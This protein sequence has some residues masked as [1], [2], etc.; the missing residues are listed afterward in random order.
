LTLNEPIYAKTVVVVYANKTANYEMNTLVAT[1]YGG[2]IYS[3]FSGAQIGAP[4]LGEHGVTMY[5]QT[6]FS[7][8][9][10]GFDI[11][12]HVVSLYEDNQK[13]IVDTTEYP[14]NPQR[15]LQRH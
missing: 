3:K 8:T 6:N 10:D 11:D 13:L 4:Q 1:G 15:L 9:D 5:D 12:V 14:V 7:F 2:Q